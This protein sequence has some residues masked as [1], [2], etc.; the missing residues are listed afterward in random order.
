MIKKDKNIV[1]WERHTDKDI[2]F[3]YTQS[4]SQKLSYGDEIVVKHGE[5]A[6]FVYDEQCADSLEVGQYTLNTTNLPLLSEKM[7]RQK[8]KNLETDIYFIDINMSSNHIWGSSTPVS[9]S[10]KSISEVSVGVIGKYDYQIS[11]YSLFVNRIA[12]KFDTFSRTDLAKYIKPRIL[13]AFI[14][15]VNELHASILE[16]DA[17][18]VAIAGVMEDKLEEI[19]SELGISLTNI[20]IDEVHLPKFLKDALRK[21]KYDDLTKSSFSSTDF[22]PSLGLH[23]YTGEVTDEI[24]FYSTDSFEEGQN[25]NFEK[26][27]EDVNTFD[28]TSTS[29]SAKFD[30]ETDLGESISLMDVTEISLNDEEIGA[31]VDAGDKIIFDDESFELEEF[32]LSDNN[33]S[34][35]TVELR[36]IDEQIAKHD[37]LDVIDDRVNDIDEFV[38]NDTDNNS[39]TDL[40]D[41][42]SQKYEQFDFESEKQ[43]TIRRYNEKLEHAADDFDNEEIMYDDSVPSSLDSEKIDN[44]VNVITFNSHLQHDI[45]EEN[46]SEIENIDDGFALNT[47][48]DN[49]TDGN[50]TSSEEISTETVIEN[51]IESG[52]VD[53]IFEN[54][55]IVQNTEEA[56]RESKVDQNVSIDESLRE[57]VKQ[58]EKLHANDLEVQ[59]ENPYIDSNDI[60]ENLYSI[61]PPE[62]ENHEQNP[63]RQ[64]MERKNDLH[65]FSVDDDVI[66]E[67]V[68]LDL[69]LHDVQNEDLEIANEVR[70][71]YIDLIEERQKNNSTRLL[72]ASRASAYT[73]RRSAELHQKQEDDENDFE[74]SESVLSKSVGVVHSPNTNGNK[75]YEY[76]LSFTP[77]ESTAEQRKRLRL[78]IMNKLV[79]S[80][81]VSCVFVHLSDKVEVRTEPSF[82][83]S[84]CKHIQKMCPSCASLIP[85]NAAYCKICGKDTR[86][87]KIMCHNCNNHV[88]STAKYCSICGAKV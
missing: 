31:D 35:N 9:V 26:F 23:T 81:S 55:E 14:D 39:G 25:L 67:K 20:V 57:T 43:D 70:N 1:Q 74:K 32:V 45:N 46:V 69:P 21:N 51:E 86:I 18:Y 4:D 77:G 87:S 33:S 41:S 64:L 66:N 27:S 34:S 22:D 59:L 2:M 44:D 30:Y 68:D 6:I 65:L 72:D 8:E 10:D 47:V 13:T 53:E 24:S 38:L 60:D 54:N 83:K 7:I 42:S 88:S 80:S 76:D 85:E 58:V 84:T 29:N 52:F 82:S 73:V 16:I 17:Y 78:Q 15:A 50:H 12:P 62:S 5:V 48:Y 79:G 40:D 36:L 75:S 3:K 71:P 61:E 19:F 56:K 37:V 63:V 11:D 49:I 28:E